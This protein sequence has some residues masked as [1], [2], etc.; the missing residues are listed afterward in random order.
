[1][2]FH[3]N[4]SL[5]QYLFSLLLFIFFASTL[6][7]QQSNPLI[8]SGEVL[9]EGEKLHNDKK[10]KEAIAAYKKISRSDTNYADALF[11]LS[12]TC[13][14]DSQFLVS[15][16]YAVEGMRLFPALFTK[17]AL[18]DA[19]SLDEL[20]RQPEAM[21][22]YEAALKKNPHAY[23]VYFNKGLAHIR[24][25]QLLE[26]KNCFQQCLLINPYYSSAHYYIAS[27]YFEEGNLVPAM[28]AFKTYLMVAPSG[29]YNSV[30]L[31]KVNSIA[32]VTDEVLDYVKNY[33]AQ[34]EDNFDLLQQIV[35]SKVALDR[36]YKL[37]VDLEDNIVRQMQ[38]VD[39]KL[40]YNKNDKGFAMQ[41]YVPLYEKIYKA[42]D[43]EAMIFNLFS[44]FE[45][46]PVEAWNKKNKKKTELYV[47]NAVAYLNE[48]RSTRVLTA[49][50]RKDAATRYLF[51]EGDFVGK[52]SYKMAN[53]KNTFFGPWEFFYDNGTL[54]SKGVFDEQEKKT[55][56]WNYYHSNGQLKEKTVYKNDMAEGLSEGW[57]KNGNKWFLESFTNGKMEG[58]QTIYY[59]NGNLKSIIQYKGGEKNG[60]E[61]LYN[62][63]GILTGTQEYTKDKLNGMGIS[64][65]AN[66]AVKDQATYKDDKAQGSYKSFYENGAKQQEGDF[67]DNLRQGLWTTYYES[68]TVNEKTMY[69]DNEI[70]GEFTEYYENGKLS[71]RGN[72]TKKK[73]DGKIEGYDDD[74]KL[75]TD[76]MYEKGKLREINFYDK[77]GT[78][79]FNT[80]TRRGAADITF[81]SPQGIKT[82]EGHFDKEGNK[83]GRFTTYFASGKKSGETDYKAG[84]ENGDNITYYNNGQKKLQNTF[85]AGVEDGYVKSYFYNGKL[86]YEGWVI[87]DQK[88]QHIIYYNNF[89]DITEKAHYLDNELDGY[90]EFKYPKN[91][92]DYEHI[93][94]NGWLEGINQFDSTG[95]IISVNDFKNGKGP[96]V[97]K[98]YSGKNAVEGMYD[99]YMLTGSYK[100]FFFDGSLVSAAFYKNDER[101]SIFKEYF[102]GG[103]L[104]MEG[105]YRNGN[106]TGVWKYYYENGK[107]KEEAAY[108]DGKLNGI[109]KTY[110]EDGSAD[111]LLNYKD[112][113]IDG[114]Y[115]IFGD[116]NQLAVVMYFKEGD[117]QSYSYEAK[118][119]KLVQPILLKGASG[120]VIAYYKNGSPSADIEYLDNDGQGLRKFFYS[121]GKIH[122][123]GTREFG[124]DNGVKK[125]Y[126]ATG[127]IMK[128]ENYVLGNYHG[129]RKT[130]FP[131]G[132]IEADENYYNDEQ[133][134]TCKY[135]DVQGK[136]KQTRVYFYGNLLSVK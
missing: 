116:N 77:K 49:T 97:F 8:N 24:T 44:G 75:Y 90:T 30:V 7:A 17:F 117:L 22:L 85:A 32:K 4:K 26:A 6:F 19:N 92:P 74:G 107:L 103:I 130:Y 29:K 100:I 113:E 78:N 36:Q 15:H 73:I 5:S 70:T 67:I 112:N 80:T 82:S 43:F 89:G 59:Y 20:E 3:S 106:K 71:R 34:K 25:K 114:E 37:Q 9:K 52:G 31:K 11:E 27:L 87:Q 55:G 101:D 102:Y 121:N 119:G 56:E 60:T 45:I 72:Y 21:A 76:A 58:I 108:K 18:Q 132:K 120:K 61:K 124:Y 131:N 111:K 99:H 57:F 12:Y 63:S 96:L 129:S 14:A 35:L 86:N 84:L 2:T 122:I 135:Y 88:Q 66:G 91:I 94:H 128:E 28:L 51:E 115:K 123:D 46:K 83:D 42:Q 39:E 136:L 125:V 127:T 109:D 47:N 79:I 33:K 105:N 93:Y 40:A 13:Y 65:Y 23:L 50:D 95:K 104:R 118:D 98:H 53:N 133:H 64:L 48:I 54:K 68:G 81:Y 1:M 134:G 41:F 16:N 110:N 10:Y 69:K 126:Y 38:V 62:I